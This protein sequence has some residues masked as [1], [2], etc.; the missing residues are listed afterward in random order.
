[1]G[2]IINFSVLISKSSRIKLI[3]IIEINLKTTY[4]KSFTDY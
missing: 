3:G 1:M 2:E 4:E